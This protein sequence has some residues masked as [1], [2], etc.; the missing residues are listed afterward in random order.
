MYFIKFFKILSKNFKGELLGETY[1]TILSIS[2]FLSESLKKGQNQFTLQRNNLLVF[3]T[4]ILFNTI[5][6]YH[7][8]SCF[9]PMKLFHERICFDIDKGLCSLHQW[10]QKG[11]SRSSENLLWVKAKYRFSFFIQ[12]TPFIQTRPLPLL[13][14]I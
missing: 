4:I 1:F 14:N 3:N 11:K 5:S 2:Y 9:H 7:H 8:V 10:K 12:K 13:Q 6:V